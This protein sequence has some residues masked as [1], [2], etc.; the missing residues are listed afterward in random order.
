MN[1]RLT[2]AF[3][4]IAATWCAKGSTSETVGAAVDVNA[5]P[6]TVRNQ[7]TQSID[8]ARRD[9]PEAFVAVD[10]VISSIPREK[11]ASRGSSA[12]ATVVLEGIGSDALFPMLD[13]LV[14]GFPSDADYDLET[15]P[16]TQTVLIDAVGRIRD[17]RSFPILTNILESGSV[18]QATQKVATAALARLESDE[19]IRYLFS[20]LDDP[21]ASEGKRRAVLWGIGYCARAPVAER[22]A[23]ELRSHPEPEEAVI[24]I[25]SL[26]KVGN[27]GVW[28]VPTKKQKNEGTTTKRVAAEA[29]LWSFSE[30]TDIEVRHAAKRTVLIV[31]DPDTPQMINSVRK[32]APPELQRA[33]D[34]LE[35][36][37]FGSSSRSVCTR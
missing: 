24:L 14:H 21:S 27:W 3:L 20:V 7:L 12:N 37:W 11:A 18:D 19:V 29:A 31:C 5:L 17:P 25:D 35:Q 22:L 28:S 33:P 30:Y 8:E 13:L 16:E 1:G 26:G 2:I 32:D 9:H 4:C 15:W 34:D 6:E 23:T 36:S 10:R